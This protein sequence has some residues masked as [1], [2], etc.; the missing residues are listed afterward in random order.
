MSAGAP[1]RYLGFLAAATLVAAAV[2]ALGVPFTRAAAGSAGVEAMVAALGVCWVSAAL[3]GLPIVVAARRAATR[4]AA[5]RQL[6]TQ[7][8]ATRGAAMAMLTAAL[9]AMAL[10]LAAVVA[11]A[12]LVALAG[13]VPR[14][15]FLA[16]I[17]I[18]YLALLVVETW[19]AVSEVRRQA[20]NG[21]AAGAAGGANEGGA[22]PLEAPPGRSTRME[23][24]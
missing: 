6:T 1:R 17:G 12:V 11:G 8:S 18:G 5:T 24:R 2:G 7:G 3:G 19:Y 15:P 23:T 21:T 9:A 16:W 14:G 22:G 13:A 20:E 4:Q 10:R